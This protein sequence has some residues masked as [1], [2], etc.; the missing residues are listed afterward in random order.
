MSYTDLPPELLAKPS[1]PWI[2]RILTGILLIG[3]L[4]WWL[5]PRLLSRT[6]SAIARYYANQAATYITR[7]DW[8]PAYQSI[9][10]AQ[11][12]RD[13]H[14]RVLRVL[15]DFLI[16]TKGEPASILHHLRLIEISGQI[17]E[18]D[19]LKMG[20]IHVQLDDIAG[21][22]ATLSKLSPEARARRPALEL[23]ANVQR[24]QGQGTQAEQTLRYALSLDKT[25]PMCQLRLAM[26][27]QQASFVE[28][29]D[30]ARLSL[31]QMAKGKDEAALIA[32]N[33][34]ADDAKLTPAEAD[35]LFQHIEEHPGKTEEAR[36]HVLSSVLRNRPE[37]KKATFAAELVRMKGLTADT[38]L[39]HLIWLLREKQPQLVVEFRPKDFFTKSS[40]LIQPYLHALGDLGRWDE[41]DRL[42]S[43]PAGL[44]V[45]NAFIAL[46]RARATTNLDQ[47]TTRTRQH[48]AT[49]YEA[50]GHGREAVLAAAA[51]TV[52]EQSGIW[53]MAVLFY[54]GLAEHQPKSRIPM[55]EKV[56]LA[57]LRGR[58]TTA[59]LESTQK[60]ADLRPE[61]A[62]YFHDSIYLQLISGQNL[63]LNRSKLTA[64]K[65][66]EIPG[67]TV[68]LCRAL[69]AYRFGDLADLRI[70][71]IGIRDSYMLTP[72]QRAVHAGL[73]SVSGQVGS[74]FQIAEQIPTV[75]L[76]KEEIGFL[77]RAL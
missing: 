55:L 33:T 45:S 27:D 17:T 15:A 60:L 43:R 39:P 14:P 54:T 48:L 1:K 3:L 36:L 67:S 47:D 66:A 12:W 41:V 69:A 23:L 8:V 37:K 52:A 76:L 58:D 70:H 26:M 2:T 62:Q 16:A 63:E 29:R 28:I 75:L 34:L 51:A 35:L 46:W 72:G 4:S 22:Q 68:Y 18:A 25:D 59:L 44:P 74:A 6:Q 9:E 57:A 50:T 73:L 13:N 20:Q 7:S 61:N 19:L 77:H 38:L 40:T 49:A 71:L 32:I 53:D 24:L 11:S 10:K 56:R 30:Q 5:G 42:L 65:S 31:W 64:Q 21:I